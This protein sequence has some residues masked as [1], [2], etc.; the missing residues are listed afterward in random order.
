MRPLLPAVNQIRPT[1]HTVPGKPA[2]STLGPRVTHPPSM[3]GKRPTNPRDRRVSIDIA[4]RSPWPASQAEELLSFRGACKSGLTA[5]I[6]PSEGLRVQSRRNT[7]RKAEG[8]SSPAPPAPLF[9][10]SAQEAPVWHQAPSPTQEGPPA[11]PQ[12]QRPLSCLRTQLSRPGQ[13]LVGFTQAPWA[14]TLMV[15]ETEST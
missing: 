3:K 9:P 7:R 2:S 12:P 10:S 13:P 1:N 14:H 8:G 4:R 11:G 6:F 5:I 15:G